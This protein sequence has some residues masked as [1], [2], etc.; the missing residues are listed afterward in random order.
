MFLHKPLFLFLLFPCMIISISQYGTSNNCQSFTSLLTVVNG[1][2]VTVTN[3]SACINSN[4][5]K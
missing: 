1:L 2:A 4:F 3:C 5:Y